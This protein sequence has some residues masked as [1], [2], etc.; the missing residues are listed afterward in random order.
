MLIRS[1]G[2]IKRDEKE[3]WERRE[4]EKLSRS[5]EIKKRA[6]SEQIAK[7]SEESGTAA[8]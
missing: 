4:R 6:P 5:C 2:A 7:S 1:V 8:A 3:G